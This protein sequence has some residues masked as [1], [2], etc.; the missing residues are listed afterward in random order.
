MTL[1]LLLSLV[2]TQGHPRF[3]RFCSRSDQGRSSRGLPCGGAFF[4]AFPV[5]GRGTT[6]VCSAVAPTGAKGETLT[7]TRASNGTCTKTAT[8]GLTTTAI[9][10]GDLV[11]LSSNVVRQEYDAQGFIGALVEQAGT[12][13]AVRSAEICNAA[14]VDVGTPACATDQGP[15]PFGTTTMDSVTDNDGAAFEGRSQVIVS[16]SAT[17]FTV[18]CYVKWS[19]GAATSASI[20]LTGTGSATGDCTGTKSSLSTTTSSIVECTSPAAYAGTL[21]A[22]TVAIRVGT[23]AS[24]QGTLL[25]EGCDVK[26]SAPYRTSHQP[27]TNIAVAR[28]VETASFAPTWPN[29]ASISMANSFTG[30]TPVTGGAACTLEFA[31]LTAILNESAGQWRFFTVSSGLGTTITSSTNG[32]RTYGYHTGSFREVA[33]GANVASG[34]DVNASNKFAAT[35]FVGGSGG[36]RPDG[37]ISRVCVD[38]DG[39][40]CR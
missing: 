24:D 19:S 5:N 30:P 12:N 38:Q 14:W 4:E 22:V 2:V 10:D 18:A 28:A 35:L 9:A 3:E 11:V 15:G 25:I 13:I 32:I 16:T 21:T 36:A 40:R 8:G 1:A 33:W 29:S 23:V 7:F 20:T 39:A 27:T 34:A 26:A 37:I 17:Q 6:G 31:G